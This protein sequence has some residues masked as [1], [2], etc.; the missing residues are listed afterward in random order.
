M[1]NEAQFLLLKLSEEC[2]EVAQRAAKQMQY[3]RDE[4]Q[5]D[6]PLTNGQRLREE[7]NDLLGVVDML[8]DVGEVSRANRNERLL[9]STAKYAKMEQYLQLS[10][11]LGF[12]ERW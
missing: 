11:D 8:E 9:A 5:K 4:I 12:V 7:L 10:R 2:A 1:L 3:G 6:Q